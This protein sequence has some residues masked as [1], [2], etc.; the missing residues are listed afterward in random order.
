MANRFPLAERLRADRPGVDNQ[1]PPLQDINY[2]LTDIAL[3]E[4]VLMPRLYRD[5]PINSIWEGSGN[6]QCLD[7]L[8]VIQKSPESLSCLLIP[9]GID[10]DAIIARAFAV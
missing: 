2:Y 3:Q 6:I 5:A 9:A 4:A 1:P 7:V 8:R 10:C